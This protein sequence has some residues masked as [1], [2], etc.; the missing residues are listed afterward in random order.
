M[1]ESKPLTEEQKRFVDSYPKKGERGETTID[2]QMA[3]KVFNVINASG[4]EQKGLEYARKITKGESDRIFQEYTKFNQTYSAL[5]AG[6]PE[7]PMEAPSALGISQEGSGE[8]FFPAPE[9]K[10]ISLPDQELKKRSIN[11]SL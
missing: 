1:A 2:A 5:A 4:D 9:P 3:E 6:G 8:S 10:Q 11:A 7:N